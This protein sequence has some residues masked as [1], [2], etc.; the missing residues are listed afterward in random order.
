MFGLQD[1][2]AGGYA[3]QLEPKLLRLGKRSRVGV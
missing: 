2:E 3:Q 1:D